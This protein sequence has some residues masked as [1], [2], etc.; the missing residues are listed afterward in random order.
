MRRRSCNSCGHLRVAPSVLLFVRG[1]FRLPGVLHV[2]ELVAQQFHLLLQLLQSRLV[3]L[4]EPHQVLVRLLLRD[5]TL[6]YL[7]QARMGRRNSGAASRTGV[8]SKL[9]G[10]SGVF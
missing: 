9:I 1:D 10:S 3:L 5:E 6:H 2:L 7:L 8:V 4:F